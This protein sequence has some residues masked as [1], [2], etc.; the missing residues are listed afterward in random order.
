MRTPTGSLDYS[1]FTAH[2]DCPGFHNKRIYTGTFTIS[3][4]ISGGINTRT[5][6][7][8]L[9]EEPSF[10]DVLFTGG[11]DDPYGDPVPANSWRRLSGVHVNSSS[12]A[13][14]FDITYYVSGSTLVFVATNLWQSAGTP[15]LTSTTINYRIVDYLYT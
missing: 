12:G 3:G 11:I 14:Y 5:F 9:D 13:Q 7:I 1:K 10:L 2:S 15:T 4:S 8:Q 6:V